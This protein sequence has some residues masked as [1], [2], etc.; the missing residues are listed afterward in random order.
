MQGGGNRSSKE[1]WGRAA[2]AAVAAAWGLL[3]ARASTHAANPKVP[4]LLS[5]SPFN[6][7][8]Y[9]KFP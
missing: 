6:A 5:A 7:T 9:L 3:M 2:V 1:E 8:C 4:P